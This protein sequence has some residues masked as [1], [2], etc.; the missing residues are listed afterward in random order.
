DPDS[1]VASIMLAMDSM[2]IRLARGDGLRMRAPAPRDAEHPL[3]I[4]ETPRAPAPFEYFLWRDADH[5]PSR[6]WSVPAPPAAPDAAR[7]PAPYS[8]LTPYVL[9]RNR[10][11]GA[12]V[13]DLQPEMAGYFETEAGVLV[14]EVAPGTPAALAGLLPGDVVTHVGGAGVRSVEDLRIGVGRAGS[15]LEL[16]VVRR[17]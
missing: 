15:R 11:A 13:I 14:I 8:P 6:A 12:E 1:L 5:E 3:E 2:R 16:G 17:G 9:G 4:S 7:A 10:V